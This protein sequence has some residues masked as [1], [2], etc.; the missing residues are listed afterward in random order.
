M[1]FPVYDE[2]IKKQV[3]DFI[4]IQF[5]PATKT[6]LLSSNLET[7]EWKTGVKQYCSQETFYN[8]LKN[9]QVLVKYKYKEPLTVAVRVLYH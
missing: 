7:L 3:L 8:H 2:A 4:A 9:Q 6:Q 1:V 5:T